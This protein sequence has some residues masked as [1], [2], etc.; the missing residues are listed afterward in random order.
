MAP[1]SPALHELDLGSDRGHAIRGGESFEKLL[2]QVGIDSEKNPVR[3]S[4][5]FEN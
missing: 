2:L 4:L 1:S 5:D 3:V